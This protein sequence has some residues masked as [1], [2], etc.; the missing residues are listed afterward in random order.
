MYRIVPKGS[1]RK[2]NM[3][4]MSSKL[5]LA[6]AMKGVRVPKTVS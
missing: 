6:N 5:S 2:A 3:S 1:F 4:I